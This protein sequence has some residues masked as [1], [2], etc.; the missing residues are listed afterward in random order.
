MTNMEHL[1]S[2]MRLY[3]RPLALYVDRASVFIHNEPKGIARAHDRAKPEEIQTQIQRAAHDL[4]INMIYAR[5]PQAKGR[6][7]CEIKFNPNF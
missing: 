4:G 3:G 2:Y 5:S 6:V 1:K 7:L